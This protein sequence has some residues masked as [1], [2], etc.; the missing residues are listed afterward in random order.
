MAQSILLHLPLKDN[1]INRTD[2]TGLAD[3]W[4][5]LDA[6]GNV[7]NWAQD[8]SDA[9]YMV[10]QIDG[11]WQR[12]G[13]GL[14]FEY[15]TITA[16]RKPKVR[17]R[18]SDGTVSE[19]QLS[20]FEID[21]DDN[22]AKMFEFMDET[23]D[24]EWTHAKIGTE[25]SGS[26]IVGTSHQQSS[27]GVGSYLLGTGYALREVNHNHQGGSRTPSGLET[28]LETGT[29]TGDMINANGYRMDHPRVKLNIY[30]TKYGYSPYNQHGSLDPRIF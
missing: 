3:D 29:R 28:Y 15:G 14:L 6:S 8:T 20:I 11:R 1:P 10:D 7:V 18:G 19:R 25:S 2:M 21:G 12:T 30:T 23:T 9:F 22:A 5:E 13:Q 16:Y 24:V 4:Y 26:N 27:T 17:V